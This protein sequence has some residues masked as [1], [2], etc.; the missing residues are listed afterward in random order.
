MTSIFDCYWRHYDEHVN[1]LGDEVVCLSSDVLYCFF[2]D[3]L[4]SDS[5]SYASLVPAE[6]EGT[7]IQKYSRFL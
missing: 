6:T 3:G 2:L 1:G 5:E 4:S 7:N